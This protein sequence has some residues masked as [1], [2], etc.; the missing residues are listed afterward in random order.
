[1]AHDQDA[2][3]AEVNPLEDETEEADRDADLAWAKRR[4]LCHELLL[5]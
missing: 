1:M 4:A 2:G 3:E 5:H